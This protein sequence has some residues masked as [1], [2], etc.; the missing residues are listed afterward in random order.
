MTKSAKHNISIITFLRDISFSLLQMPTTS[1][2]FQSSHALLPHPRSSC[3]SLWTCMNIISVKNHNISFSQVFKYYIIFQHVYL[4]WFLFSLW[5]VI[6]QKIF[7]PLLILHLNHIFLKKIVIR[8]KFNR[9]GDS[10]FVFALM[11]FLRYPTPAL[12]ST[13]FQN[14]CQKQ[15]LFNLDPANLVFQW[16]FCFSCFICIVKMIGF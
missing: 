5:E 16:Q 11:R 13:V 2:L 1:S 6:T 15:F 9:P 8:Q 3:W 10:L 12:F 4:F 14:T 7:F